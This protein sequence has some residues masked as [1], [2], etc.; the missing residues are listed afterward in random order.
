MSF[1]KSKPLQVNVGNCKHIVSRQQLFDNTKNEMSTMSVQ[2]DYTIITDVLEDCII[3]F[4]NDN[5][6]YSDS[7]I[8]LVYSESLVRHF[9]GPHSVSLAFQPKS[10]PNV[11]I[12]LVI[13][14]VKDVVVQN[15]LHKTIEVNFL[16]L[17]KELR[18]M[19]VSSFMID[20]LTLKCLELFPDVSTAFYTVGKK[21]VAPHFSCKEYLHRP[22]QVDKL[23][24]AGILS[25]EYLNGKLV[26]KYE[27]FS[28]NPVNYVIH[29]VHDNKTVDPDYVSKLTVSLESY[30]SSVYDI[31]DVKSDSEVKSLLQSKCF[32]NFVIKNS[33][34]NSESDFI[35]L[36]QLDSVSKTTGAICR[37]G[38]LYCASMQSSDSHYQKNIIEIVS[39][40]CKVHDILDMITVMGDFSSMTSK[41]L[42]GAGKLYYYFF[43]LDLCAT[44]CFKNGLITI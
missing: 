21:L 3:K 27:T 32:H 2:L 40:Y 25:K 42:K 8:Q 10:K 28:C 19:K 34:G 6:D 4:I 9:I 7:D 39:Q 33:N 17:R 16:C 30:R 43:N 11:M 38:Y 14:S 23:V 18:S 5:Y 37:N 35:S 26:N 41:Y 12:G 20:A 15:T 22:L 24:A 44:E 1:W 13:G 36:F 31:Y 29:Y